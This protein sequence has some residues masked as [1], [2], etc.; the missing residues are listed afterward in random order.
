M[1]CLNDKNGTIELYGERDSAI[2]K[3]QNSSYFIWHIDLCHKHN[4]LNETK[5]YKHNAN[6][7]CSSE[8]EID[9]WLKGKKAMFKILNYD[10]KMDDYNRHTLEMKE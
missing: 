3:K 8:K 7:K 10:I 5:N 6:I 1:Y 2:W 4:E 9:T